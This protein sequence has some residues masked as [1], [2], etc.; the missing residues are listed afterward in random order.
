MLKTWGEGRVQLGVK[1]TNCKNEHNDSDVE[2]EGNRWFRRKVTLFTLGS[3]TH[4]KM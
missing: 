2:M 3:V 1:G 4:K